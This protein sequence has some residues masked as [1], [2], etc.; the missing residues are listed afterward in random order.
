MGAIVRT[1]ARSPH[2]PIRSDRPSVYALRTRYL[3][4]GRALVPVD[5]VICNSAA[6]ATVSSAPASDL[7]ART[8]CVGIARTIGADDRIEDAQGPPCDYASR[9]MSLTPSP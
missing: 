7:P 6:A 5:G 1:P 9:R 8:E 2:C 4:S 3:I